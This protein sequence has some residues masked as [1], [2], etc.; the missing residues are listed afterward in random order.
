MILDKKLFDSSECESIINFVNSKEMVVDVGSIFTRKILTLTKENSPK[1]IWDKLKSFT[2]DLDLNIE[3]LND[4]IFIVK[5]NTGDFIEK[6]TDVW[7]S[8]LSRNRIYTLVSQLSNDSDYIGGDTFVYSGTDK[9]KLNK[10][11]GSCIVFN[12]S[13]VHEVT[14]L[15]SGIRYSFVMCFDRNNIKKSGMLI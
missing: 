15:K 14:K 13:M 1:W 10:E 8:D 2:D 3:T 7:D 9:V 5:F 6:H 11:I 12:S 4:R